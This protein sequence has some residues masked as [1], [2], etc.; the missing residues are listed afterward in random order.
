MQLTNHEKIIAKARPADPAGI[1]I[2]GATKPQPPETDPETAIAAAV[3]AIFKSMPEIVDAVI[4]KAKA[5]SYLHANFLFNFAGADHREPGEDEDDEEH[6]SL[7]DFL[8]KRLDAE[9]AVEPHGLKSTEEEK[10][11]V[12][13]HP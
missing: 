12:N 2:A 1:H 5:G 7:V 3:E 11:P 8:M 9:A 13:G 4:I 10:K 6:G